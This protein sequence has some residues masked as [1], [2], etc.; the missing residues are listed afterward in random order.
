VN[1]QPWVFLGTSVRLDI[2]RED[3]KASR[4]RG[5]LKVREINGLVK[6]DEVC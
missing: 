6:I 4:D 5:T 3:K 2:F 1:P